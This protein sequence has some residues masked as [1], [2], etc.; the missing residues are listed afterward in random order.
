MSGHAYSLISV[1]EADG[2][3]PRLLRLRNPW[4]R[5]E[6]NGDYSDESKLWN[7]ALSA[8]YKHVNEDDG[9][10]FM[11]YLEYLKFFDHTCVAMKVKPEYTCKSLNF[12]K[13]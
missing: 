2:P 5:T 12:F 11:P 6:W 10:F 3:V 13:A 7:P 1:H 9:T 4:G 8:K